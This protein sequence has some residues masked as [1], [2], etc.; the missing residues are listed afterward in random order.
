HDDEGD[1]VSD[2][3]SAT[4]TYTDVPPSRSEERRVGKEAVAEGT[5]GQ[6]VTYTY[7]ITNTSTASTDPVTVTSLSD[8]K[9][10]DLLA[11][12][13][14][15]NGNSAVLAFDASVT[16]TVTQ[17]VPAGNT[18]AAF[19]NVVTVEGHDDEGDAVSDT[20]SAT[21]TYTDVPPS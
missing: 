15:A 9:A 8:D 18:S 21:V 10:G 6:T 12:F 20:A 3:A 17:A 16:F 19:T 11:A 1:A 14:T 13:K 5:S 7:T 4:V 2:T